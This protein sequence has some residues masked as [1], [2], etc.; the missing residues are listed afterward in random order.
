MAVS[1]ERDAHYRKMGL[2]N[3][4]DYAPQWSG[5]LQIEAREW[6]AQMEA[7]Q[8]AGEKAH[9][10]EE[11][12]IARSAKDE[13]AA[14]NALAREANSIARDASESARLSALA[15]KTNNII[16]TLALIAAVIAMAIS[17][18]GIFIK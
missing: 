13:A 14:A 4:R 17:I 12:N 5:Q 1:P 11:L 3:V 10:L 6:I 7:E 9:R 8:A 2:S 16:A 15:A 18:V